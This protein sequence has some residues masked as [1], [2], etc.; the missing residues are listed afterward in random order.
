[1]LRLEGFLREDI[2]VNSAKFL[3]KVP[4]CVFGYQHQHS[5]SI[6]E[7]MTPFVSLKVYSKTQDHRVIGS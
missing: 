3:D 4:D 6:G 7:S 2:L 5:S 1:M